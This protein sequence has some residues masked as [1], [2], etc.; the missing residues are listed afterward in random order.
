MRRTRNTLLT[1]VTAAVL[2][3][4]VGAGSAQAGGS[5]GPL[6]IV[7]PGDGWDHW[8]RTTPSPYN[9]GFLLLSPGTQ[10]RMHRDREWNWSVDWAYGH[11]STSFPT[12]GY[13]PRYVLQCS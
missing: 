11:A 12:D 1:L 4:G 8:M 5:D 6:C 7:K 13:I 3:G 9:P 2:A 10:F